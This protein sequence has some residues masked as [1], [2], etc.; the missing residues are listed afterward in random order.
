MKCINYKCGSCNGNVK[1]DD[2]NKKWICEYCGKVYTTM[3]KNKKFSIKQCEHEKKKIYEYTCNNCG[4]KGIHVS[5]NPKC[6]KCNIE[7][8]NTVVVTDNILIPL[9]K[10]NEIPKII[11]KDIEGVRKLNYNAQNQ[12]PK[13]KFIKFQTYEG[14]INFTYQKE[15]KICNRKYAFFESCIPIDDEIPYDIK[16]QLMNIE[17]NKVKSLENTQEE[18]TFETSFK[19][20]LESETLSVEKIVNMCLENL[21]NDKKITD[22]DVIEID[23]ELKRTEEMFIPFYISETTYKKNVQKTYTLARSNPDGTVTNIYEKIIIVDMAKKYTKIVFTVLYLIAF[24]AFAISMCKYFVDGEV[25]DISSLAAWCYATYFL[26]VIIMII[27]FIYIGVRRT[28]KIK[29]KNNN[30]FDNNRFI[31]IFDNEK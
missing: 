12:N 24:T 4:S 5:S 23:N 28:K 29:N 17:F 22:T 13:L 9:L 15:E 16:K 30:I 7:T 11:I 8:T 3:Y 31:K 18:V 20:N 6:P 21:K 27:I 25:K 1:F 19:L 26:A 10:D 2:I 14:I